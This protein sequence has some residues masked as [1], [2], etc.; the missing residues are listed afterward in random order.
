VFVVANEVLKLKFRRLHMTMIHS[1][2]AA[3]IINVLFQEG[4]LAAHST[5][6][7][8]LLRNDPEEQCSQLLALL[9]T[10][11]H[12]EAFLQLYRALQNEP[13]LE[14]LVR[15]IDEYTDQ[16]VRNLLQR[17]QIGDQP[18]KYQSTDS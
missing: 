13:H 6:T 11:E 2:D 17:Q 14:W 18:G 16:E 8:M 12:P 1:V 9:H 15:R 10:S 4:V 3:E 7:L 5:R